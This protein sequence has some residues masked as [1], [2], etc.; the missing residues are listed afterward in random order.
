MVVKT[1]VISGVLA[2]LSSVPVAVPAL[3]GTPVTLAVGP[4][5]AVFEQYLQVDIS[6]RGECIARDCSFME[7]YFGDAFS[8]SF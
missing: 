6:M 3:T 2:A 1:V 5:E 7:L 4:F 8:V